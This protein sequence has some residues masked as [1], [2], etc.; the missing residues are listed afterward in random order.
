MKDLERFSQE[1]PSLAEQL[2]QR[3]WDHD[4]DACLT[5]LFSR[6]AL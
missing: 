4:Q 6:A 3:L 5:R 2:V 1:T